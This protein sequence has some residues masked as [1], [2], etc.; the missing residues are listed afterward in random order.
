MRSLIRI[1]FSMGALILAAPMANATITFTPSSPNVEQTVNFTCAAPVAVSVTWIFGDGKSTIAGRTVSHVYYSA[2]TF[3]VGASWATGAD[4]GIITIVERRYI[5]FSPLSP[6]VKQQ[7]TFYARN[8]L[9]KSCIWYFGD[10]TVFAGPVI[11]THSYKKA[12][13]YTVRA[14]D[15]DGKSIVP[16]TTTVVIGQVNPQITF[17]PREPR[18]GTAVEFTA[19]D[20]VSTT[21]IR[22][23]FGDGAVVNDTSPPAITHVYNLSGTFTVRA[24]DNGG[25]DVSAS[26]PVVVYPAPSIAFSPAD[27]RPGRPV[28]FNAVY[29]FSTALIRW[30]FGDGTVENDTTPPSITHSYSNPGAYTVRAYDGGATTPTATLF[31]QVWPQRAI[32][33]SPQQVSVGELVNFRAMYFISES[34]NWNFGDGSPPV[35]GGWEVS[36]TYQSTGTF[37][38]AATDSSGGIPVPVSVSLIVY[39]AQGPRAK[40]AVSYI[41][42]RFDDGTNYKVVSKNFTPLKAFAELKYE[43]TGN[44]Y[45]QWMIDGVPFS[46]VSQS[47]AFAQEWV[48]DSGEI[49]GLPTIIPG[50][51][52]VTLNI[53]QPRVEFAIP[54]I[55]YF[56]TAEEGETA[57]ADLLVSRA[58]QLDNVEIAV[59]SDSV[60]AP[61]RDYFLLQGLVKNQSTNPLPFVLLRVYLEDRLIDQ[62]L[63]RDLKP[64]EERPF[65][66]SVYND[67]SEARKIYLFLYDLSQKASRLL[68]VKEVKIVPAGN[69]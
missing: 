39:P 50:V 44:F 15:L 28:T 45:A 9:L 30:D 36:H 68:F 42:L 18:P 6:L 24:Y 19:V 26:V 38:V 53:I 16:I 23:D 59:A 14:I 5:E 20:F 41:M 17:S 2:G 32:I 51:H 47:L 52:E 37:T 63:I 58:T 55:R 61:P 56:V 64:D 43:G 27:P 40:F 69:K 21:L 54:S 11:T 49:P 62:R 4:K 8:Y 33:Y 46:M 65:E 10:G 35:Q 31:V 13:T 34:L 3:S 57:L 66:S 25:T 1:V 12:G 22:W 67:S 29:F 7:I 60:E 48:F